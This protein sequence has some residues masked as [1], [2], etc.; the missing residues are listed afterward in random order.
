MKAGLKNNDC[1]GRAGKRLSRGSHGVARCARERPV[2]AACSWIHSAKCCDPAEV[3]FES[4]LGY[5]RT[6]AE[7]VH[8][9]RAW[10][11]RFFAWW[12]AKRD[13]GP[14]AR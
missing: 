11:A 1:P 7:A 6:H 14:V 5:C 8:A 3:V 4:G 12:I 9:N 2:T 13:A 10:L